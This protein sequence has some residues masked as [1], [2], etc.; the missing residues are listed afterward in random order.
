LTA[1]KVIGKYLQLLVWPAHL[2]SD[3]SYNQTPLSAWNDPAMWFALLAVV[4]I[5][6]V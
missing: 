4:A 3:R 1:I 5:L 2:A 6:A